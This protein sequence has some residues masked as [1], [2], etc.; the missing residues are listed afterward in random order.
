MA[1]WHF[2]SETDEFTCDALYF[3]QEGDAGAIKI[4]RGDAPSRIKA[5]QTGN[6]R[7]LTLLATIENAGF[8]EAFWH[9]L[10]NEWRIRGEWFSPAPCLL[11]CIE[12][13]KTEHYWPEHIQ[14]PDG[15]DQRIYAN[16]AMDAL[17]IYFDDIWMKTPEGAAAKK[18]LAYVDYHA[19]ADY[20]EE[21]A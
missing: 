2:N 8:Q 10:F 19:W 7:E 1:K 12:A 3:I 15:L 9:R 18:A 14:A 4:G 21:Y 16:L 17:D 13:A 11:E 5:L 20:S 6:P